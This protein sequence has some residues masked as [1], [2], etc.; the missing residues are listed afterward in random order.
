M[1]DVPRKI[2]K[3]SYYDSEYFTGK[4]GGKSFETSDGS[5]QKWS[6]FNPSGEWTGCRHIVGAWKH[7]FDPQN[8]LDVGC[9]RGQIIAYARDIDI[10]AEGFDFSEWAIGDEGRYKGTKAEWVKCHDATEKWP[11]PD[12]SFDLVVALDLLEHIYAEDIDFV[13]SE[14][15]RVARKW[16]FLQIAVSGTGGLQGRSEGGYSLE[17]NA[18]VPIGLE[19]CAVAGHVTVMPQSYWID[20]IDL[21]DLFLRRDLKEYFISLVPD[22]VIKNWIL[23]SILVYEKLED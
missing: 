11:Y 1:S 7:M 20:K 10:E 2:F 3:G 5:I 14:I 6:Y 18:A 22:D 9:G 16:V 4:T 13:L 15:N 19:G 8:L 21:D 12:N 17:K 23:N